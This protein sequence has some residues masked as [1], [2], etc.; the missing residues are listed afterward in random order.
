PSPP[1]T[2][3]QSMPVDR[4]GRAVGIDATHADVVDW[5]QCKVHGVVFAF[6]KATEGTSF[7]DPAFRENWSAMR[8]AGIIRGAYHY[9][10]GG[11]AESQ[12]KI[13]ADQVG[14]AIYP[15][16]TSMR[17]HARGTYDA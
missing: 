2:E 13:F 5:K 7:K 9:M 17:T 8:E 10:R 15:F 1:Q 6:V 3:G 11:N 16:S 4:K 14:P 12:A